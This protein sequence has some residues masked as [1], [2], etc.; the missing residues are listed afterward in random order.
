MGDQLSDTEKLE[1]IEAALLRMPRY[2][3]EIYL[4]VRL[5]DMPYTDIA[6][7][8]GLSVRQVERQTTRALQAIADAI[9]GRSPPRWRCWIKWITGR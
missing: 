5:D 8:T 4:A 2:R 7:R 9:D 6:A 1:R 3:R